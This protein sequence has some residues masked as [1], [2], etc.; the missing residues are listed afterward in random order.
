MP[1]FECEGRTEVIVRVEVFLD[2]EDIEGL[3][4]DQIQAK[5]LEAANDKLSMLTSYC[6]NGGS[7]KLI[8]VDGDASVEPEWGINWESAEKA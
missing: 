3:D 5:A 2:D 4:E 7:D 1:T 8:G 6:G